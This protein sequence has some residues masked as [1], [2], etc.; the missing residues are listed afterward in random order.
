MMSIGL[1]NLSKPNRLD[2]TRCVRS[3]AIILIGIIP[4]DDFN[5]LEKEYTQ[6]L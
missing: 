1:S 3:R 4:D 6:F 2:E 5:N